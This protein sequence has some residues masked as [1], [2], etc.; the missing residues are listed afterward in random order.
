MHKT[1]TFVV[2]LLSYF[3]FGKADSR[4]EHGIPHQG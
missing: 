3:N 2:G 4:L 1:P